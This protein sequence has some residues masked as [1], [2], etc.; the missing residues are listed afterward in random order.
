MTPEQMSALVEGWPE[1]PVTRPVNAETLWR[2]VALVN[3]LGEVPDV[4]HCDCELGPARHFRI[5]YRRLGRPG[6]A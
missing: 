2:A 3:R 1:V 6:L 5:Q 4:L